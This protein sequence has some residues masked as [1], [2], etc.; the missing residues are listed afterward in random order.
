M[1]EMGTTKKVGL[2]GKIIAAPL[3]LLLVLML[4][5]FPGVAIFMAYRSVSM[6]VTW[7][8]AKGWVETPATM[9]HL[10]LEVD[11]GDD[12]TTYRVVC[13]Y[14][15]VFDGETYHSDRVGLAGGSDNI[16]SW[17]QDTY[18]RLKVHQDA[19]E[20]DPVTCWVNPT[21][22]AE[23]VLDRSLRKGLLLSNLLF[24]AA[25]GGVSVAVVWFGRIKERRNKLTEALRLQHSDRPWMCKTAW[26]EGRIW[27]QQHL[28]GL[29]GF[30][31]LWNAISAPIVLL[32][33]PEAARLGQYRVLVLLLFP[34]IGLALLCAAIAATLR[35]RRYG[36]SHFDME[37][38]PGVVGG[39]LRGTLVINGDVISIENVAVSLR[40]IS[41]VVHRGGSKEKM[42]ERIL[43]E[44]ARTLR[45]G[46]RTYGQTELRLP[47]DFQ[48]PYDCL[49]Y[50]DLN[51]KDQ[52]LWQ[53][54]AKA[55]IPGANLDLKFDVPVFRTEAS[56][57]TIGEAP[58]KIAR[59]EAALGDPESPLPRKMR[60]EID[61]NG[62]PV[63]VVSSWPGWIAFFLLTILTAG[64]LAGGGMWMR[65]TWPRGGL[66]LVL[67]GILCL[68]GVSV[69]WK[70]L[71]ALLGSTRI[72]MRRAEVLV[73]RWPALVRRQV[74]IPCVDIQE[75]K[76]SESA[77][78]NSGSGMTQYYAVHLV[79][80][81]GR[82]VK[83]AGMI[84]GQQATQ[85]L[86]RQIEN[87]LTR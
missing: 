11:H 41:R 53:L 9:T 51:P 86:V 2:V 35:H 29:W 72:T 32:A 5:A 6:V 77:Q 67:P 37:T 60:R 78:V 44:D 62:D 1:S 64:L 19:I 42:T 63:F 47:V 82:K 66:H 30:S 40:C 84:S 10:D 43:W 54:T 17:H 23:A 34:L 16:G 21:N 31:I 27:P 46:T 33:V 71:R 79:T 18:N 8:R 74:A 59:T 61:F 22:P 36:R 39:C 13:S 83:L 45:A 25:F 58:E 24:V 49:P 81:D 85:W 50:D 76:S 48:I 57:P 68:G 20:N 28:W 52:I 55:D 80:T 14:T 3:A 7:Q 15:Y 12:S 87:E 4:L 73:E 26:A 69:F 38:L 56:R 65:S 70:E 75:I